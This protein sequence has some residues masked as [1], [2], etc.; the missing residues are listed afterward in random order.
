MPGN[1]LLTSTQSDINQTG[2]SNLGQLE[3]PGV[4]LPGIGRSDFTVS[5]L[6]YDVPVGAVSAVDGQ[7]W[8]YAGTSASNVVRAGFH[9][10]HQNTSMGEYLIVENQ[11]AGDTTVFG[12]AVPAY[13]VGD[14]VL[15]SFGRNHGLWNLSWNDLTNPQES[16]SSTGIAIPWLDSQQDLYVGVS[17]SNVFPSTTTFTTRMGFFEVTTVPEPST[18]A[19]LGIGIAGMAGYGWRRRR[20]VA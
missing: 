12:D 15:L 2:H 19:L 18:V 11:G 6:F 9:G 10:I 13:T 8:L 20:A 3:A 14:T 16:A 17:A 7:V 4:F 5:G 1:L